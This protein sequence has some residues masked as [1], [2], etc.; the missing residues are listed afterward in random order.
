M[1]IHNA[2]RLAV[3]QSDRSLSEIAAEA[4]ISLRHLRRLRKDGCKSAELRQQILK[5][6]GLEPLA[7]SIL[8]EPAFT[9]GDDFAP[10]VLEFLANLIPEMER[11]SLTRPVPQQQQLGRLTARHVSEQLA[12]I[13]ERRSLMAAEI[14]T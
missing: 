14:I 12:K 10:F 1:C 11:I 6:A 8:G 9:K 13:D 5:A 3:D 4:G 2:I 7:A